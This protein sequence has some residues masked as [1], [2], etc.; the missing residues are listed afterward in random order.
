M[1]KETSKGKEKTNIIYNKIM[2][3]IKYIDTAKGILIMMV[4]FHH[5]TGYYNNENFVGGH[6]ELFKTLF[7]FSGYYFGSFRMAAF[8]LLFGYCSHTQRSLKDTFIRGCKVLIIPMFFLNFNHYVWFSVAMLGGMLIHCILRKYSDLTNSIIYALMFVLSVV[9]HKYGLNRFAL[10]YI[11]AYAPFI[12]LGEKVKAIIDNNKFAIVSII[13]AVIIWTVYVLK[14]WD[15][16][17]IFGGYFGCDFI[18]LPSFLVMSICGTSCVC[19]IARLLQNIDILAKIGKQSLVVYL[20]HFIL[21]RV[22]ERLLVPYLDNASMT[23]TIIAI[24]LLLV[25]IVGICYVLGEL[26]EKYV[27]CLIGKNWN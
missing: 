10:Q 13:V 12:F 27:P 19:L 25:F 11:L 18:D 16:P 22:L 8:F 5:L 3:R 23:I 15:T 26:I 2:Q 6:N 20:V 4:V 7:D 14:G 17:A 24:C 1:Q 9:V 21:V